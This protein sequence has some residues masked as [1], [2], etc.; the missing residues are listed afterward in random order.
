MDARQVSWTYYAYDTRNHSAN[1]ILEIDGAPSPVLA[2]LIQVYAQRI[3]GRRP[4][5]TR[6]PGRFELTYEPAELA[7]PTVIFA[8]GELRG[9]RASVDGSPVAFAHPETLYLEVPAGGGEGRRTVTLTW[10]E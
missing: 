3:A 8:P 9:V 2:P 1:G 6:R 10:E 4:E 5:W 7:A